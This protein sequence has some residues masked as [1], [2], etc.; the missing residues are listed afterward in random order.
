MDVMEQGPDFVVSALISELKAENDRKSRTIHALMKIIYSCLVSM[1]LVVGGFLWYLNQYDFVSE[2]TITTTT[3]NDSTGIYSLIDSEGN[4]V[5]SDL[6]PDEVS[7]L[8]EVYYGSNASN[9]D[10]S[11]DQNEEPDAL[12][13]SIGD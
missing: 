2:S 8:M 9:E 7:K 6:T 10:G 5:A 11:I 12:E 3:N 4:V 13:E 1:L